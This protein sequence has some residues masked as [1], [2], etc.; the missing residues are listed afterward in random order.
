MTC[1]RCAALMFGLFFPFLSACSTQQPVRELAEKTA[2][3]AGV[4]SAHLNTLS[5][6]SSN[7]ADLRA[8]NIARLHA[9]NTQLRASYNYDIALTKRSGR[10]AKAHL[11]L[12]AELQAW[13]KEI[14]DIFRTAENAEKERK[15]AVLATQ[16]KLDTQSESLTRIAQALATLAREETSAERATFLAG[17]A[18]E[19]ADEIKTHLDQED[20][21]ATDAKKL[22]EK[23]K[24]KL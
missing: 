18:K 16:T 6:A 24:E 21:S 1:H 7:L 12:I 20:K 11:D 4:I 10:E 13:G 19:L 5:L 9:A 14:D 23:V 2:A 15:A 17:Y 3:N 8:A 22:L